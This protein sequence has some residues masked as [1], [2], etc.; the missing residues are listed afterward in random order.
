MSDTQPI[1]E[2]S[3]RP[4]RR[5]RW[6]KRLWI[7]MWRFVLAILLIFILLLLIY[8]I[9]AV[10]QYSANSLSSYLSKK[11]NTEIK[12]GKFRVAWADRVVLDGILIRDLNADTLLAVEHLHLNF[13]NPIA[14]IVNRELTAEHIRIENG[15][16][17]I[18][19]FSQFDQNNINRLFASTRN[20][21]KKDRENSSSITS[22]NKK[23]MLFYL[24]D[25][26]L[27]RF[28]MRNYNEI[29]GKEELF[30]IQDGHLS[31]TYFDADS[32]QI[33]TQSIDLIRPEVRIHNFYYDLGRYIDIFGPPESDTLDYAFP[34]SIKA[35]NVDIRSG[36][37]QLDNDRILAS[38]EVHN[39]YID[40]AH[41]F[42]DSINLSVD[43]LDIGDWIFRGHLN[44][45]QARTDKGFVINDGKADHFEVNC[46]HVDI[47]NLSL[48]TGRSTIV[49]DIELHYDTYSD[50]QRFEDDV[51]FDMTLKKSSIGIIDLLQ[52]VKG[53]R[54]NPFFTQNLH[55][56]IN[57]DG[58]ILG[59]VN[60]LKGR[61]LQLSIGNQV[62]L[63]GLLD[64]RDFTD[65][66]QTRI[67][68]ELDALRTSTA[69]IQ[70]LL[71]NIDFPETFSRLGQITLTGEFDG[72]LKDF[73]AAGY[74]S[75]DLGNAGFDMRLNANKGL[76]HASYYGELDL[77]QFDL[78]SFLV[79]SS[80]G[81][82]TLSA[83]IA[84]GSGLTLNTARARLS[85][86]IRSLEFNGYEYK[87]ADFTGF[88]E[89]S[90]VDGQF[91]IK[92]DHI[93]L[94]WE[95]IL[96][97]DE[98]PSL[99]ATGNVVKL[100]LNR[101]RLS[102]KPLFLS[103]EFDLNMAEFDPDKFTGRIHLKNFGVGQS[104]DSLI[105]IDSL[106]IASF[107]TPQGEKRLE[108]ESPI[109]NA[110][111]QGTFNILS[112]PKYWYKYF[113]DHN[114]AI[115]RKLGLPHID[116]LPPGSFD[117]QVNIINSSGLQSLIKSGL[118]TLQDIE[119]S[120]KMHSDESYELTGSIPSLKMDDLKIDNIQIYANS[121][122]NYTNLVLSHDGLKKGEFDMAPL[123]IFA[124]I[125]VDTLFFTFN[126]YNFQ[127]FV[128]DIN[129]EGSIFP[130]DD[131]WQLS[132]D[133]S[134]LTLLGNKWD[135]AENNYLRFG[136]DYLEVHNLKLVS[137]GHM[138]KIES[139]NDNRGLAVSMNDINLGSLNQFIQFDKMHFKGLLSGEVAVSNIRQFE[140]I[141][142]NL[143]VPDLI[144]NEDKYGPLK[145]NANTAGPG[146]PI[147]AD[148][149]LGDKEH[150]LNGSATV[151]LP[152]KKKNKIGRI[153][154]HFEAKQMPS[155]IIEYFI[156]NGLSETTGFVDVEAD[157]S[158][159]F[160]DINIESYVD[161]PRT[162]FKVD[163]LGTTY[164]IERQ[165]VP[166]FSDIIDL[167]GLTIK[168]KYGHTATISGGIT[169]QNLA[170]IGFNAIL[171]ADE[172][173]VMETTRSDNELY[174]GHILGRVEADFKGS[175]EKP[176]IYVKADNSE[177][178]SFYINN[179]RSK[180]STGLD[181]IVFT[182]DTIQTTQLKSNPLSGIDLT[183][184]LTINPGMDVKIILNEATRDIIEARG[185][186]DLVFRYSPSGEITLFGEYVISQGNYLFTYSVGGLVPVTKPFILQPGSK[187]TWTE[188]PFNA[189][190]DIR[191]DYQVNASPANLIAD[192]VSLTDDANQKTEVN[193]EL[194]LSGPM[195]QPDINFNIEMPNLSGQIKSA[196]DIELARIESDPSE[197]QAQ[198]ASLIVF[199]EFAASQYSA[200]S[201][202]NVVANTI[203]EWLSNQVSYYLTGF[204]AEIVRNMDFIDDIQFDVGVRLPSGEFSPAGQVSTN[205]SEV[206]L[207][208]KVIMFDRRLE[209]S[210]Q[211]DFVNSKD[212]GTTT[213]NNYF[214]TDFELEYILTKDRRWRLRAYTRQDQF[215]NSRR[216]KSGLGVTWRRT[217]DNLDEFKKEVN[218]MRSSKA[219]I[220]EENEF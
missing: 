63:K 26:E 6:Y 93:H 67:N 134:A 27:K 131:Q 119:L 18:Q 5:R 104:I 101:L 75:T 105:I 24:E 205:Q 148:I 206:G 199:R 157:I 122:K 66:N 156:S 189:I 151:E 133:N 70:K 68:F 4:T 118:D 121:A 113:D 60:N 120:G 176:I 92:D 204:V 207:S 12:I 165:R 197:L 36:I 46:Q 158:G 45:L 98:N 171:R 184:D 102:S 116:E 103:G 35:T 210:I 89:D 48:Q 37:L 84:E 95:G 25:L 183:L 44:Q 77:H 215:Y 163:I 155:K 32:I 216:S 196:V 191:A 144:I 198:A 51:R 128:D 202:V 188:D 117:F 154:S 218:K 129:I 186:G 39:D 180:E 100:D 87:N 52:F 162:S 3:E 20:G 88:I 65:P 135:V 190:L 168:D 71:P 127:D 175:V 30:Y 110:E 61:H 185:S 160:S 193:L 73:K 209:A 195:F 90:H 208:T 43:S 54:G 125:E 38:S 72:L 164:Y 83:R 11:L 132:L 150:Y 170:N 140:E 76:E 34:F 115:A 97:L 41:L 143:T 145:L 179:D 28:K 13:N 59:Y 80:L 214:N 203:G 74:L 42:L 50:F 172:M 146:T 17:N 142:L 173:L 149:T 212:A 16:L 200:S 219:T 1:K 81:S 15:F 181:F 211:G 9:P 194:I 2:Q 169:H 55:Q 79:D 167:T 174:Y 109:A 47:S 7:W 111:V 201:S 10:Q 40:F 114:P 187:L 124:D 108:I 153:D 161:I 62:V 182:M 56:D 22:G 220:P 178:S 82:V 64:V 49:G 141:Q 136:K 107:I 147:K 23:G 213:N 159:P 123:T 85:A 166:V 138:I 130:V 217:Y 96:K 21:A 139:I 58:R 53:L 86:T 29:K 19:W 106:K 91:S 31:Q 126:E 112:L 192:R 177:G 69:T 57:I 8:Q 78:G 152:N 137:D 94:N 14:G 99:V 33:M